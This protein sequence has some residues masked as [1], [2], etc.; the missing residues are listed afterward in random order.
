MKW[1]HRELSIDMIIH[2]GIFKDNQ[3]TLY[4]CFTFIPKTRVRFYSEPN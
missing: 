1:S 2:T 3:I 4:P